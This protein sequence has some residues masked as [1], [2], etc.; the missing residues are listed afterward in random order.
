M[1]KHVWFDLEGTLTTRSDDFNKAHNQLRYQTFATLVGKPITDELKQE[2]EELYKVH[3]SNSAVFRS[4]GRAS[5]F[6]QTRFNTLDKTQYYKPMRAIYSTVEK[7]QEKMPISLFTNV[8]PGEVSKTLT[9]ID[10]D[11][12]W[13]THIITGDDI[14]ERKPAL[15]GFYVMIEKSGVHP[16][17]ILYVGDRIK[18]DI[19]PAKEVGIKTCLVWDASS[20]A[21]Y[22]FE[23]F[24]DL[25]SLF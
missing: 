7:L 25:L 20:E 21:D 5:D 17:E 16:E 15:D 12:S 22:S 9:I 10:I 4:L 14:Q 1:I 18:V 8:K 24:E 2:F 3:G 19:L 13:F 11:Q 23:Q 6:W